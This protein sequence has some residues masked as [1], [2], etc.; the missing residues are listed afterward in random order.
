MHRLKTYLYNGSFAL[1]CLLV[2]LLVFEDRINL[3]PWLQMV[4]RMHPLLLHFPIVLMVVC[5]FL[6]LVSGFKKTVSAEQDAIGDWLLLAAS[7]TA[8]GSALMGLLLSKEEGY[9]KDVLAWHKWGG[10]F[11][12][13]FTLGWYG[14][15]HYL[16]RKKIVLLVA[17]VTG[18]VVVIITGHLGANITHGENF[19]L[20]PVTVEKAK[21][22]I[23]L[24]DAV[25][26][27]DMVQPIIQAKCINCHNATKAKG[28]LVMEA[29]ASL[30]KGGKSGVLWDS[31]Q[32]DFGLLMQR[33][34]LPADNKKH[35]P[36][37]GKPQLT[38]EEQNI[39]YHWI[40]SGGGFTV[41]VTSLPETD[42]LRMLANAYFTTIQTDVYA[43]KEADDGQIKSLNN[44]YRHV[45]PLAI[46]SPAL[47]VYFFG[48]AQFNPTQLLELLDVKE[49]VVSLNLNKMPVTDNDLKTI[50][51]FSNLR[52][53]N[54]SFTN[55][56]GNGLAA[57]RPLTELKHLALSGTK[58]NAANLAVLASLPSLLQLIIWNTPAQAENLVALQKQLKHTTIET[59]FNSDTIV[60]KLNKPQIENEQ[61]IVMEPVPLRIKH[62]IK[63]AVIRYTTDGT[64]P[65]SLKSP[66]YDGRFI[67]DK[68]MTIKAKAYKP[69]WI[70]SD[71]T[72]Q[73]FYKAGYK[74]DSIS[75]T[76]LPD[77]MYKSTG[78]NILADAQNGDAKFRYDK[79]LGYQNN[80][81][82]ATIYFKEFQKISSVTVSALVDVGS[83]IMPPRY[84]EVWAGNEPTKLRLIKKSSPEQLV[85]YGGNGTKGFAIEFN[86][87]KEKFLKVVV[88]PLA[89]LPEWHQAKG[90]KGW[91]FVDEIFLN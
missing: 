3:P 81:L 17:A 88:V 53:L 10:V 25:V 56:T 29:P 32:P 34:H 15:R 13:L 24:G 82:V 31:A 14:L 30:L 35:M 76:H 60:I 8:V 91:I 43:F 87:V 36:P 52:K 77:P 28:E 54:L 47:G 11:I 18:I 63:G 58:I 33:L 26:F 22:N 46:G 45:S 19:L 90:Q 1:N 68:N 37:I 84:L 62:F 7:L 38:N 86:A 4:G 40:R 27:N 23:L 78:A 67:I 50:S 70:T 16:K 48:A 64:E 21:P 65:D 20:A 6:E 9:A 2:F 66:V 89:K 55:I 72:E 59:G 71:M 73:V 39:I 12:S 74:I 49:Q 51:K 61:R 41:K 57:L 44:N 80:P 75:L 79:W 85:K 83:S 42:T 5:I 69:G